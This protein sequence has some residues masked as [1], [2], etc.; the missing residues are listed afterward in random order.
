MVVE[1][2]N[3]VGGRARTR[4]WHLLASEFPDF[5][6]YRVLDLGGT[7]DAWLSAPL[8]PAHVTVLNL[9]EPGTSDDSWITPVTGDACDAA[10][11]LA[12]STGGSEYDFVYSNAVL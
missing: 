11:V 6:T 7:V 4:R 9:T 2:P 5:E 1:T 12:S 8:R 10:A 3:S